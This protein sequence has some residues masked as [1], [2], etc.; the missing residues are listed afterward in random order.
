MKPDYGSKG[1]SAKRCLHSVWVLSITTGTWFV[2]QAL[3]EMSHLS[4]RH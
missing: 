4:A 3:H 1:V 2:G